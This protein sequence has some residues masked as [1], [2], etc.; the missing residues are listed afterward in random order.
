MNEE[1]KAKNDLAMRVYI[2]FGLVFL[3]MCSTLYL[4]FITNYEGQ[5]TA[6]F[7][8]TFHIF[9]IFHALFHFL[10]VFGELKQLATGN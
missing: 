3:C 10:P 9:W 7:M 2:R 1:I 5:S 6:F 4:C 8:L